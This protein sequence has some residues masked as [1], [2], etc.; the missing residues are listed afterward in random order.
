[1][2]ISHGEMVVVVGLTLLREGGRE[3]GGAFAHLCTLP[4]VYH[5][6]FQGIKFC[7]IVCSH[8]FLDIIKSATVAVLVKQ[9]FGKQE[10]WLA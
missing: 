10:G 3:G 6:S 2:H 4:P 1:M 7:E 5:W 9:M 8:Q